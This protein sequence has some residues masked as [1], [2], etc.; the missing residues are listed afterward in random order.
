M[1]RKRSDSAEVLA[2]AT[3]V[4]D[5]IHEQDQAA[6]DKAERALT[7]RTSLPLDRVRPRESDT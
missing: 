2:E 4:A 1:A 6:E 5:A 3:I 7:Q